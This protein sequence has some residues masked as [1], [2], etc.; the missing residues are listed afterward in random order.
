MSTNNYGYLTQMPQVI[1]QTAINTQS[2]LIPTKI[3]SDTPGRLRLRIAP[4]DRQAGKMQKIANLLEAQPNVSQVRT[5]ID[6]GSILIN[7]DRGD[8]SLE[9]VLSTLK[10]IGIIFGDISEGST[11]AS[12]GVSNAVVDLNKRVQ[13]ATN[14]AMDLR[15]LFPLGLSILSVRQL[16][17]KG[18][19]FETIPWYVLAWYAFDSFIKLNTNRQP[20]TNSE[21]GK[22]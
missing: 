10:D 20:Q 8:D 12:A 7:H 3:I 1:E 13:Q 11:E 17:I 16:L 18:L 15:F 2:K 9:N 22:S 5:N 6:R 21:Y 14:G 4:G 19:Q